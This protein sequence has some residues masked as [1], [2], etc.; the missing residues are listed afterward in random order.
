MSSGQ[1]GIPEAPVIDGAEHIHSGKVRDLYRLPDG[2]L[3]IV[4]SDRISAYDHVLDTVI[5]DKGVILTQ[6]SLWWFEQLAPVVVNHVVSTDVP[7]QVRGRAVVCE[8][9]A[10]VPV[11]LLPGASI[12]GQG[13]AD[14]RAPGRVSGLALPA[15][16]EAGSGCPEPIFTPA[17]K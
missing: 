4:A 6:I 16:P 5:P 3:L 12:P 9:L 7:A 2:H 10:M 15:G 17:T 13:L 8:S 11:E 1:T 14:Y